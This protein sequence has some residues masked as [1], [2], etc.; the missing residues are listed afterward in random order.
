V[1]VETSAL[2]SV[3]TM[4]PH[5][6]ANEAVRIQDHETASDGSISRDG[7]W[8]CIPRSQRRVARFW[9][10]PSPKKRGAPAARWV[11]SQISMAGGSQPAWRADGMLMVVPVE[12]GE[13]FFRPGTPKPLFQTG[14][15]LDSV[16]VG[17]S[18]AVRQYDVTPDGQRFSLNQHV[19]ASADSPIAV[20]VNWPKLVAK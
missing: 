14:L 7:L 4:R 13:N 11:K 3:I 10:N 8:L 15:E 19:A 6:G 5:D 12:S 20:V 1:V 2:D 18:V 17:L 9:C 16:L